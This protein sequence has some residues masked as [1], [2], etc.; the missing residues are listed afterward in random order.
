[1]SLVHVGLGNYVEGDKILVITRADSNPIRRLVQE[2]EAKGLVVDATWG[3]RR[4]SAI[5]M[6]GGV[7]VLSMVEPESLVKRREGIK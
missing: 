7:I 1:M 3:R 5:V 6:A 2:A 4:R